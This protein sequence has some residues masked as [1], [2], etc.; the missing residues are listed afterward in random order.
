MR[1]RKN[2]F[3]ALICILTAHFAI[4]APLTSQVSLRIDKCAISNSLEIKLTNLDNAQTNITIEY[5]SGTAWFSD[6]VSGCSAYLKTVCL[7]AIPHGDYLLR[8]IN[9][10]IQYTRV[11]RLEGNAVRLFAQFEQP[12]RNK[13]VMLNAGDGA[14]SCITRLS[15]DTDGQLRLQVTNLPEC[16]V[17]ITLTGPDGQT[18]V[19]EFAI[20]Q[21]GLDR[22]Y[23]LSH[24]TPGR[25]TAVLYAG[26]AAVVQ[27]IRIDAGKASLGQ[28]AVLDGILVS[29][30]QL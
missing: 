10:G 4:S 28:Q 1:N 22:S 26:N 25:Y 13:A 23:R 9:Q 16:G 19:Q 17:S 15:V 30:N 21:S 18:Q 6:Q 24:L 5:L 2:L 11:F 14:G 3:V 7:N 29:G 12:D 8:A 20:A 27:H